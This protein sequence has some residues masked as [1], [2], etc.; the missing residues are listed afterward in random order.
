M[1][2]DER[3]GVR[4]PA[5][6]RRGQEALESHLCSAT[7]SGSS[8]SP[9]GSAGPGALLLSLAQIGEL[10]FNLILRCDE[11]PAEDRHGFSPSHTRAAPRE[12]LV[13]GVLGR[14]SR[15]SPDVSRRNLNSS[16]KRAGGVGGRAHQWRFTVLVGMAWPLPCGFCAAARSAPLAEGSNRLA[17]PPR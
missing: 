16:R 8:T 17:G 1:K 6:G 12:G 3:A 11:V 9:T 10:P 4:E 13:S 15:E 7:Q 2:P 14:R 5:F